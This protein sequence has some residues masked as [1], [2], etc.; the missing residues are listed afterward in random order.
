MGSEV[1]L[2]ANCESKGFHWD[3]GQQRVTSNGN[4]ASDVIMLILGADKTQSM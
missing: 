1:S 2:L 3:F 4:T